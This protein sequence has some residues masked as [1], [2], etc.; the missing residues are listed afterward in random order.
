MKHTIVFKMKHTITLKM[1]QSLP[2]YQMSDFEIFNTQLE[3]GNMYTMS[4]YHE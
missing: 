2:N 3:F 4:S 1:Y